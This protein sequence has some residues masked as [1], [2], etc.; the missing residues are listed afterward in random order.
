MFGPGFQWAENMKT[1]L[2][3]NFFL[4]L[5]ISLLAAC[6]GGSS[7]GEDDAG[8]GGLTVNSV[9]PTSEA[10]VFVEGEG[11]CPDCPSDSAYG[12][13]PTFTCPVS[14]GLHISWRNSATGAAGDA[15]NHFRKRCDTLFQTCSC[16]CTHTWS[17]EIDLKMGENPV[18]IEGINNGVLYGKASAVIQRIPRPLTEGVF[19]DN[20]VEGVYFESSEFSGF[21]DSEGRFDHR[22]GDDVRLSIGD[23]LLG[24]RKP[25]SGGAVTPVDL[26]GTDKYADDSATRP[27]D[28]PVTN[29][30]R[31][32]QSL[33][34]DDM[35]A[36]GISISPSVSAQAIGQTIDFNQV[37]TTFEA[38]ANPLLNLLTSGRVTAL[39]DRDLARSHF[40]SVIGKQNIYSVVSSG[41]KFNGVVFD[42]LQA[43]TQVVNNTVSGNDYFALEFDLHD[44]P[45]AT[46]AKIDTMV[47]TIHPNLILDRGRS[48]TGTLEIHRYIG[49]GALE[50]TDFTQMQLINSINISGTCFVDP[51]FCNSSP[52]HPVLIDIAPIVQTMFGTGDRYLGIALRQDPSEVDTGFPIDVDQP[53]IVVEYN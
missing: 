29:M 22:Q 5:F 28:G 14:G 17:A 25:F 36:N 43:S 24:E 10:K 30:L 15:Q 45:P 49:N 27:I 35:P 3:G 38:Q 31:F 50:V 37:E 11:G 41:A 4:L 39:I 34:E 51:D 19:V 18:S 42:S 46:R 13:C 52:I 40:L 20:F 2:L 8:S 1:R 16:W 21:T 12:F 26:V 23:I 6:G 9:A 33:D 48:G 53:R 47:I 44:I 32:L 7:G